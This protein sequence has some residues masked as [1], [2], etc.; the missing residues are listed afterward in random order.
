[1]WV[2]VVG[3]SVCVFM[4]VYWFLHVTLLF[5]TLFNITIV[6]ITLISI[7]IS[8]KLLVF[9]CSLVNLNNRALI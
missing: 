9:V 4:R 3:G 2:F 1:M 6:L 5:L 8:M 7:L